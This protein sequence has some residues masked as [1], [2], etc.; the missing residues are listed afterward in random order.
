MIIE[1]IEINSLNLFPSGWDKRSGLV[2]E[3][4]HQISR[5]LFIAIVNELV[6][7]YCRF[8]DCDIDGN[9]FI[10]TINVIV[11]YRF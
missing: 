4:F 11:A 6:L 8:L 3:T 7:D 1:I 9:V 2:P 10:V 5:R